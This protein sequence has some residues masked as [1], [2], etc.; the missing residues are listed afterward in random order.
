MEY[1]AR[2]SKKEFTLAFEEACKL[3]LRAGQISKA[4]ECQLAIGNMTAAAGE[5]LLSQLDCEI[6]RAYFLCRNLV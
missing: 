6:P 4:V 3:F 1:R 5:F 2:S